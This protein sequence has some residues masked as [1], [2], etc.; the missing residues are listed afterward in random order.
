MLD[1][2]HASV[3]LTKTRTLLW[4]TAARDS[5]DDKALKPLQEQI[6]RS[7]EITAQIFEL[8]N[9]DEDTCTS[10]SPEI[11]ATIEENIS[12]IAAFEKD[13]QNK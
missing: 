3:Y 7:S 11:I 13:L 12:E 8:I 5:E 4:L 6:T 10:R 9:A 1:S 2:L